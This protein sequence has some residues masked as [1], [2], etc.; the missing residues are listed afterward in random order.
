MWLSLEVFHKR[1]QL[2]YVELRLTKLDEP[3]LGIKKKKQQSLMSP[4]ARIDLIN[5]FANTNALVAQKFLGRPNGELFFAP[6]PSKTDNWIKTKEHSY[7]YLIATIASL[8][9]SI[10]CTT[11]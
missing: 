4:D 8:I 7:E 6:L 5:K 1:L 3:I 11:P 10:P 9:S 2:A